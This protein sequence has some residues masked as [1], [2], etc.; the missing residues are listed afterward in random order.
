MKKKIKKKLG[1]YNVYF[2]AFWKCSLSGS[3]TK[4]QMNP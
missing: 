3:G 2:F 1:I 4:Q